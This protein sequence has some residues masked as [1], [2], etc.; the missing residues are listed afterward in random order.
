MQDGNECEEQVENTSS[1][2]SQKL[3]PFDLNE[4]ANSEEDGA[5]TAE[6]NSTSNSS[7][8]EGNERKGVRQYVRSKMPRLRWTPDLHRSFVHAIERLGGQERSTPKLVLQAM[9]VRGLSISHVKSHLQM[10][11]SKKLDDSGQVLCQRSRPLMQ[12][13]DHIPSIFNERT[14]PLHHFRLENGRIVLAS[15]SQEDDRIQSFLQ[16]PLSQATY[17][18]QVHSPSTTS[19]PSTRSNQSLQRNCRDD[20]ISVQLYSPEHNPKIIST[21]DPMFEPPFR[22][23]ETR[24]KHKGLLPDLQLKLSQSTVGSHE[25]KTSQKSSSPDMINTMLSLSLSPSYNGQKHS[26]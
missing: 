7:S 1:V 18:L 20:T 8:G 3:S 6:E 5:K 16:H 13:R 2:S 4:E 21:V 26:H 25:E 15:N 10:Y 24:L 9:N 17:D 11:R 12:G 19:R 23:E 22:L 14:S